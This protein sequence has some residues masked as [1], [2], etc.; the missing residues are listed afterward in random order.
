MT[1]LATDG[2]VAR[3]PDGNVVNALTDAPHHLPAGEPL[4]PPAPAPVEA[5]RA[6][7]VAEATRLVHQHRDRVKGVARTLMTEA[8]GEV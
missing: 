7:T 6:G 2:L 4:L 5:Y 3:G 1:T 8:G